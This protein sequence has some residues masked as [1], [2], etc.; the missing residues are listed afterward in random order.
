M[1]GRTS[2]WWAQL[3]LQSQGGPKSWKQLMLW[4]GFGDL[5][6]TVGRDT[7]DLAGH[8]GLQLG[9]N[10]SSHILSY[11]WPFTISLKHSF[12]QASCW[13]SSCVPVKG[14]RLPNQLWVFVSLLTGVLN[15][16][17]QFANCCS[18]W[19]YPV[20]LHGLEVVSQLFELPK[21]QC[22]IIV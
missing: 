19:C 16:L 13:S 14:G 11:S 2:I 1:G 17:A 5:P 6:L 21:W 12:T 20:V 7:R 22:F 3:C 10:S 9:W 18:F 4:M 8:T 15:S